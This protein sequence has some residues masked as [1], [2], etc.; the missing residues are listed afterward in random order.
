MDY[1]NDDREIHV[2]IGHDDRPGQHMM[3][4]ARVA[5]FVENLLNEG[6]SPALMVSLFTGVAMSMLT[7]DERIP[8][9]E[10]TSLHSEVLD[11][12]NALVHTHCPREGEN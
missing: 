7:A 10:I 1:E 12:I 4:K 2:L 8:H 5:S 9:E 6:A 11:K 3:E